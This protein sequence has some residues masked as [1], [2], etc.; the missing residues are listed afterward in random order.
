M[1]KEQFAIWMN[2]QQA[3]RILDARLEEHIRA[4][5]DL[6]L[7]EYET[8]FRLKLASDH[9]LQ[10]GEISFLLINSPSGMT[11]IADRLEKQG[12][13]ARETPKGNRRVVLVSLTQKGQDALQKADKAFRAGLQESFANHLS[14]TDLADLRRVMRKLLEKNGAWQDARCSPPL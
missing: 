4:V 8:L 5:A 12:L 13:I 10:M 2:L 11:R 6:S 7:P 9:P 1:T 3:G 14:E